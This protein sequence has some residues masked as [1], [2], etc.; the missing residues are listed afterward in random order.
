MV[1]LRQHI[2]A[3]LTDDVGVVFLDGN[4]E[5]VVS[6]PF[7]VMNAPESIG[8]VCNTEQRHSFSLIGEFVVDSCAFLHAPLFNNNRRRGRCNCY[9]FE[10][11]SNQLFLQIT[12]QY[13]VS[14]N[15]STNTAKA[16]LNLPF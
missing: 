6:L 13:G 14:L 8:F 3:G 10:L 4:Q 9:R 7:A 12:G 2:V 16:L 1:P 15:T 5:H 11:L